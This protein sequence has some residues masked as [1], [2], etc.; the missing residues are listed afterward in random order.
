MER[1]TRILALVPGALLATAL[2][3]PAQAPAQPPEEQ[4]AATPAATPPPTPA[5]API[6]PAW[7]RVSFFTNTS[8]TTSGA[9]SNSFSELIGTATFESPSGEG[10]GYEY[11]AD[12]RFA[13]YPNSDS[14]SRRI[15]I[16]DAY[17]G[18]RFRDG[19]LGVR[20][21]Q[22]WLNELG[23]LGSVGGAMV[24]MGQPQRRK[25]GRWRAA[26]F[27]GL[28]PKVLDAGFVSNIL[29]AG[30]LVAFDGVDLRRH[31][32][33][34]VTLRNEGMTERSVII[35]NNLLPVSKKLFVY[36]AAE[37]D[38]KSAGLQAPGS[39]TY[40]FANA[41]FTANSHVELQG[42]YHRGRSIDSRT[43][44]RDQLDGRAV[45]PRLLDGLRFESANARV[46]VTLTPGI[47][48]Y[49]GYGRDKNN[50]DEAASNR[51]T[52]GLFASN[53]LGT[54]LD[55]TASDSRMERAGG[56][57]YNSWYLSIGRSLNR[58]LYLS[59]DYGS[60]VSVLRFVTSGGFLIETRPQTRRLAASA[61]FNVNRGASILATVERLT[62]GDSTQTRLMSGLSYR[63]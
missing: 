47:R 23:G 33:G 48:V 20:V 63:F 28:E 31:V 14:R 3:S 27:G 51:Y 21:G 12:V 15:S 50:H 30:G 41:R 17:V 62:D 59:G 39:L 42:S 25:R 49:G 37:Y 1:L 52:Y 9:T 40:L 38:V 35:V 29:K 26:L 16:Y 11:R 19:T 46:T 53:L 43:I 36:Q 55:V 54:A 6:R 45:E 5:P 2:S 13:G 10:I 4:A 22:M 56:S 8:S 34:F 58:R 61:L 7:G 44:V 60:S 24:E 18:G 57:S 32:L